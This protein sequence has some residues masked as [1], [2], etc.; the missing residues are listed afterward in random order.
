M[1]KR[2][3]KIGVLLLALLA[4]GG[5]VMYYYKT[6][7][8]PPAHLKYSNQYQKYVQSEIGQLGDSNAQTDSVFDDILDQLQ[9]FHRDDFLTSQEVGVLT[10]KAAVAYVPQFIKGANGIFQNRIWNESELQRI[11]RRV[12]LLRSLTT[13]EGGTVVQGG[14]RGQ[15]HDIEKTIHQYHRAWRIA[16]STRF[17]GLA[18]ARQ[19]IYAANI[20]AGLTSLQACTPL[21]DAL[22]RLPGILGGEHYSFLCRR[23]HG[24]NQRWRYLGERNFNSRWQ[25]VNTAVEQYAANAMKVYG[26]SDNISELTGMLR[27]YKSRA[28]NYY[29]EKLME[30]YRRYRSGGSADEQPVNLNDL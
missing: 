11:L 19:T 12:D 16:R 27:S 30:R 20:Y 13:E 22:H 8:S 1:N 14:M 2:T 23:V 18:S 7:M 24:L 26:R 9:I 4:A 6:K 21:L 15:L 3:K 29:V 10:D 28:K 25:S 5:G 17:H